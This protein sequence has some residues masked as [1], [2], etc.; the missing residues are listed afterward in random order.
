MP[1]F[2]YQALAKSGK[3]VNGVIDAESVSAARR[4]LRE[5]DIYTTE[6]TEQFGKEKAAF[7]FG[8]GTRI[9]LR[10][11]AMMTRQLAVLLQAG[12]PLV[13]S[14]GAVMDQTANPALKK[15]VFDV[16]DKVNTGARLADSMNAHSKVFGD[17]Y[18]SLVRAGEESGALE[19]VLYRLADMLET[20]LRLRSRVTAALAYPIIMA[21]FGTSVIFFL[22]AI[23]VPKITSVFA[24]KEQELPAPTKI[25]MA[26][27]H[28]LSNYW[29]VLIFAIAAIIFLFRFWVSRP[30]GRR[31]WDGLKMK[32]PLFGKLY[33]QVVAARFARTL[34]T[35]LQSGL[36]MMTA[37]D[38]VKTVLQNRVMEAAMEDVKA[39][40]RRGLNLAEPMKQT[41]FFPPMLIQ[42][43][44]LGQRSGTI[45]TMLLKVSDTYEEEVQNTLDALVSLLEPAMIIVMGMFVGFLVMAIM[46]PLL[47]MSS[48]V[49]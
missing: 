37:L 31:Q 8:S 41:G 15:V 10:E 2:E 12:M 6:M 38:V 19:Q 7:S 33:M 26:M 29:Y 47:E 30:E 23:V 28:F 27:S 25:M 43:T 11:I 24:A 22:M 9:K 5:Q 34:G 39:G 46:L 18:T 40:V 42:M 21:I 1:V 44:E 17:L 48:K 13:E 32:L 4:K 35:M 49:Q 14:L 3:R 45:E 36:T 20:Q 16:R